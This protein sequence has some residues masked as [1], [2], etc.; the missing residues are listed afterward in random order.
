MRKWQ[1]L[2]SLLF[3]TILVINSSDA[4]R[5]KKDKLERFAAGLVIGYGFS[6]IDGDDYT[7]FNRNAPLFG[8]Q[9]STQ[10]HKKWSL[11][12]NFTYV[13]KGANIESELYDFRVN[14]KKDRLIHLT[15][16]EVPVLFKFRPKG[17]ESRLYVEGG[18][19]YGKM[20]NSDITENVNEFTEVIFSDIEDNF[21]KDEVSAV[22]G[23][24]SVIN[25]ELTIGTRFSYGL[26]KF[27]I[28]D[29][30][31]TKINPNIY[32]PKEIL[33]LRNYYVSIIM[34]YRVF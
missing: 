27:Y 29:H 2:I 5:R 32:Y 26:N 6:Q 25:K 18:L 20:I 30:P 12:V 10:L 9:V 21:K 7:G 14:Y 16:A 33:F 31:I 1:F 24:G 19:S 3:I 11:D 17:T 4:Q 34:S 8:F 23:F 28:N 22:F 13:R 15:Y